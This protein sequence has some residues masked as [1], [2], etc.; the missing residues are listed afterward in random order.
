MHTYCSAESTSL[1]FK[2]QQMGR[3]FAE[4]CLGNLSSNQGELMDMHSSLRAWRICWSRTLAW[5]WCGRRRWSHWWMCDLSSSHASSHLDQTKTKRPATRTGSRQATGTWPGVDQDQSQEPD[6]DKPKGPDQDQL[7]RT[8][9]LDSIKKLRPKN[10]AGPRHFYQI[11]ERIN[12]MFPKTI[13][14]YF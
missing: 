13:I 2:M 5:Q 3:T 9:I 14:A 12:W 11:I 4:S 8:I 6:Q 7:Q 1:F 10:S